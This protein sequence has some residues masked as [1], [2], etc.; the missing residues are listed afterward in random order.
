M[1]LILFANPFLQNIA[2]PMSR[3][4]DPSR[5]SYFWL[6]LLLAA[7]S[8]HSGADRAEPLVL[9]DRTPTIEAW[10]AL[11]VLTDPD[12]TLTLD[13]ALTR[14][15]KFTSPVSAYAA[16]GFSQV[17]VWLRL[18][19]R[20]APQSAGKWILDVDYALL[21]RIDVY[22]AADGKGQ[23]IAVLGNLQPF[24][25][26]ALISRAPAVALDLA[27]GR[28]YE[29]LMRIDT[30]NSLILP[31][32]ISTPGAFHQRANNEFL[33]QGMLMAIGLCLLLFSLQ[34]WISLAD[35]VYG[36][37]ALLIVCNL[38]FMAHLFGFG[39]LYLWTDNPWLETHT[40]G[41]AALLTAC[42]TAL[43]I[44]GILGA[45]MSAPLRRAM[46][47]LAAALVMFAVLFAADLLS[48]RLLALVMGVLGLLPALL[49]VPGALARV[50]RGDSVGTY[51]IVAWLTSLLAG[52]VLYGVVTGLLGANF[53]TMHALQFGATLDMLIFMRIVL[54][55]AAAAHQAAQTASRERDALHSLAHSDA[56]TGLY[57]RRGLNA[58]LA[59][60]LPRCTPQQGLAIY[61][62][63]L[64]GF[65][66]VNDQYGH[67]AGDE[68]LGIIARCLRTAVRSSDAIART[69][70]DEFVVMAAGLQ[71]EQQATELG[72]KLVALF[73]EPF[74]LAKHACAVGVTI[75]YVVA[76]GDGIDAAALMKAAD[77]AMYAGKQGGKGAL[78]RGGGAA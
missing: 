17:P 58:A 47:M 19:L 11:T 6:S 40:A 78:V 22:L 13:G 3:R 48:N 20:V 44:E 43:F 2:R 14:L 38:L 37:Y 66:P 62:L 53:W 25:G 21:N 65:K 29:L 27:P 76:P 42:A 74:L 15:D 18:P 60:A 45:D 67:D 70:G 71:S 26:R 64:D 77:A 9:D 30:R 35:S 16:M 39:S 5:W 63:D 28:Q 57:N 23:H 51:F 33:L 49:G 59:E 1:P 7:F 75:G 56:L 54:L 10:P 50:R 36:K 24:T 68:L 12:R 55:R 46:R 73:R 52:I 31:V 4:I 8:G 34:Q 41:I 72:E 69:G 61:M 32:R